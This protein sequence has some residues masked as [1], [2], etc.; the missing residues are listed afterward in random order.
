[1]RPAT[2]Q[3]I[4]AADFPPSGRSAAVDA[5]LRDND[6]LMPMRGV[7]SL[8]VHL[9]VERLQRAGYQV[10]LYPLSW[11]EVVNRLLQRLPAQL[12]RPQGGVGVLDDIQ[13]LLSLSRR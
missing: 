1:M 4:V 3:A 9:A 10:P 6:T 12:T 5:L 11:L 8:E 13:G 7:A 2:H